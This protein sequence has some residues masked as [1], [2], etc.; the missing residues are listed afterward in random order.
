MAKRQ[1][2]EKRIPDDMR[3]VLA[4]IARLAYLY[5]LFYCIFITSRRVRIARKSPTPTSHFSVRNMSAL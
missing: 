2:K 5:A 1:K 3:L 4:G